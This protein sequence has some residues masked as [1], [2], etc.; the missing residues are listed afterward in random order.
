MKILNWAEW[1]LIIMTVLNLGIA[2]GKHGEVKVEKYHFGMQ[3][4]ATA[5]MMFLMYS[6]GLFRF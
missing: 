2:M 6:A 4:L 3:L 1:T 5:I